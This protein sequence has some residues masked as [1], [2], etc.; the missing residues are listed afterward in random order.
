M[1]DCCSTKKQD[2]PTDAGYPPACLFV[3]CLFASAAGDALHWM[4]FDGMGERAADQST[5][6][7]ALSLRNHRTA[8][9]E[10]WP[11]SFFHHEN[12]LDWLGVTIYISKPKTYPIVPAEDPLYDLGD[13]PISQQM[14]GEAAETISIDRSVINKW[15][16]DTR[17]LRKGYFSDEFSKLILWLAE[18]HTQT[19]SGARS[20]ADAKICV[21]MCGR[22]E[23]AETAQKCINDAK[24]QGGLNVSVEFVSETQ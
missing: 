20:G 8:R 22:H 15:L 7:Y 1:V 21:S 4:I 16:T 17:R 12:M 5:H 10:S 14:E 9:N 18:D 11:N 19:G 6:R 3:H 2:Y 13:S 23:I 24:K